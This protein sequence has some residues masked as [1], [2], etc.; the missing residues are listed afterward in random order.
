MSSASKQASRSSASPAEALALK[1][2]EQIK[3]AHADGFERGVYA[4]INTARTCAEKM[5]PGEARETLIGFAFGIEE[6]VN[7]RSPEP[8]PTED[9]PVS[10]LADPKALHNKGDEK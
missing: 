5:G 4:A 10:N 9:G 3:Q 7:G 6:G 8:T 2:A 1:V